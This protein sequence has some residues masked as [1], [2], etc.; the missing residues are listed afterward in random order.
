MRDVGKPDSVQVLTELSNGARGV[1]HLSSAIHFGPTMQIHLYGSEGTLKYLLAPE[2]RL[3]GA[4][5]GDLG[6]AEI[7][8]PPEKAGGW[9]VEEEFVRAIRGEEKIEF[10]NFATGVR[11]M[12]FTEAVARSARDGV[13]VRLPLEWE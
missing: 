3:L 5:K 2:D 13:E 1:Y 7:E 12:E 6:L 4:R 10:N 8:I 11:Y 9:R